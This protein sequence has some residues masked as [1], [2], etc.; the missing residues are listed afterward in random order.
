MHTEHMC[1]HR[2]CALKTLE[3]AHNGDTAQ[4]MG[5]CAAH[6]ALHKKYP[7]KA[8]V[9]AANCVV[10]PKKDEEAGVLPAGGFGEVAG[11]GHC[12]IG[13]CE[14][15]PRPRPTALCLPANL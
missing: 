14:A 10:G 3:H 13:P 15:P 1:A 7:W 6:G 12:G 5:G 2:T 8:D 4:L 9:Q 11:G